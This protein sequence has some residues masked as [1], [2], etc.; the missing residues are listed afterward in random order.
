MPRLTKVVYGRVRNLGNYQTERVELEAEVNPRE[1]AEEVYLMLKSQA[2][3]MLQLPM[4]QQLRDAAGVDAS[5]SPDDCG[6]CPDVQAEPLE[7]SEL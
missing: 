7:E 1:D 5:R 2:F 4:D 3:L 6:D